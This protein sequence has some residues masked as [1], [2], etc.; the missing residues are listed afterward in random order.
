MTTIIRLTYAEQKV[1]RKL[2]PLPGFALK[3]WA[4]VCAD[5]KVSLTG[6]KDICV[7][8]EP[9]DEQGTYKVVERTRQLT[10]RPK[11]R[12]SDLAQWN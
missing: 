5:R 7:H 1:F 9:L 2:P 10:K 11:L 6:T 4:D 8:L 12:A 3:F